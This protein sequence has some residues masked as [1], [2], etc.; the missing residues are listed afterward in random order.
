MM[1]YLTSIVIGD[2]PSHPSKVI[3]DEA[4]SPVNGHSRHRNFTFTAKQSWR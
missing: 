3:Q 4:L 2:D 1:R